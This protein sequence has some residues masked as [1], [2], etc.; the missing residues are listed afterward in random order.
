M[1]KIKKQSNLI[2]RLT[3]E[4]HTT[5]KLKSSLFNKNKSNYLRHCALS[6]WEDSKSSKHFK[7]LLKMYQDGE[8]SVKKQVVELFFQYYRKRGFPHNILTDDQKEDRMKRIIN[9]KKVL[10]EDDHLQVNFQGIDLVNGFHPH[11]MEAYYSRGEKSPYETF[12]ND[13]GLK[14]CINRW[15]EL[16]KIPNPA[17]MRRILKTRDGT[18]GVVNFKPVIAKFIYDNYCPRDGKILDPCAGYSGRLAGCIASNRSLFYHGIDPNG[19][20]AIGNMEI[21]SFFSTQYDVLGERIYKHNFRF[22]LGCAEEI[23][24][25]LN[26]KYDLIFTSPPFFNTEIYNEDKSQSSSKFDKYNAWLNN[27]LFK[28]VDES[29]RLL[30]DSGHLALNVKNLTYYKIA[31]DLCKHCESGW[32][33]EKTYNMRLSNSEFSRKVGNT[34]HIEPIF[35][36]KKKQGN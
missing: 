19:E 1:P 22:D 7:E 26:D 18:R 25:G 32:E 30:N 33:L 34:W 5:I 35:V 2:L 23:M 29:Y 15:M 36:F 16:G 12:S 6:H 31:D 11:M 10:L 28:I 24:P 8:E 13:E 20:T 21:A 4:E 27:F 3:E 17:G 9:S 14:D